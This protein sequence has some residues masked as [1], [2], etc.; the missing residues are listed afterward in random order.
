MT[1]VIKVDT[2][3]N[4]TGTDATL[5]SL[6][7]SVPQFSA[8]LT[9]D[10]TGYSDQTLQ[11]VTY[12]LVDIDTESGFASNTYTVAVAGT[13]FL[14]A[15]ALIYGQESTL[16]DSAVVLTKSTDGGSNYTTIAGDYTRHGSTY[17]QTAQSHTATIIEQLNVGDKLRVYAIANTNNQSWNIM[18]SPAPTITFGIDLIDNYNFYTKFFGYLIK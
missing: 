17:D 7:I 9:S 3:Q 12:N 1:S 15:S 14:S 5:G 6:N 11:Q 10:Q 4:S 16:R 18:S 2:I 8:R 13:Y